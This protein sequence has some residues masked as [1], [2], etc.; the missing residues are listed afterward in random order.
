MK[1]PKRSVSE[2]TSA[3]ADAF[4]KHPNHDRFLDAVIAARAKD[5]VA[6]C[7]ALTEE[8]ATA[9]ALAEFEAALDAVIY[10]PTERRF[11]F[12]WSSPAQARLLVHYTQAAWTEAPGEYG[13]HQPVH[14]DGKRP[15]KPNNKN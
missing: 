14:Y 13:N 4:P 6:S 3:L 15:T 7:P 5:L 10:P 9:T 8:Q 2:R 12:I 11:Y 1:R